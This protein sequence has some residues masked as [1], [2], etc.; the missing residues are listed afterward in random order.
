MSV[1]SL[2]AQI[3]SATG[4]LNISG[5]GTR[6]IGP[7]T[8]TPI[9]TE[10]LTGI[11]HY[12]PAALTIIARAGTPLAEVE[13]ALAE[14]N[15]ILPFEPI[16]PGAA[17]GR[18]GASTI[19]GVV[20]ANASGARRIAAGACRDAALGLS[21]IDGLGQIHRAGGR[22][23]KNVTGYDTTRLLCGSHGTLG[24]ITEVALKLLPAPQTTLT[25]RA[26]GLEDG[27]AIAALTAALATPYDVSAAQHGAGVTLLRLEGFAAS[28]QARAAAL[29]NLLPQFALA[30]HDWQAARA[31]PRLAPAQGETLW[32]IS[33]RPSFGAATGAALRAAGASRIAYD[34]AGGLVWAIAPDTADL[35][36]ALPHEGHATRMNRHARAFHPEPAANAALAAA[37]RQ[38]FDP[39]SL[40]NPA[41]MA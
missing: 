39:K 10:R 17:L 37:L 35:R 13:A 3:R 11:T 25:L 4:P 1:E 8:G 28:V 38:K 29:Q 31:L 7:A 18:S 16:L 22:V 41:R 12:D 36:A 27:A 40:F 34:W 14:N 21:F 32:R 23:M 30:E 9:S 20:A 2:A 5:G 15:Q 33:T 24:L 19:G 6:A 26:E